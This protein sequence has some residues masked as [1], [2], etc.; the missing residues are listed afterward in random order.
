MKT[1]FL[2]C[3]LSL[4]ALAGWGQAVP[5]SYSA[6]VEVP[7]ASQSE[8]FGRAL[9]WLV[10]LPAV[11]SAQ[12]AASGTILAQVSSPIKYSVLPLLLVRN[13]SLQVKD[14][15]LRYELTGFALQ[16]LDKTLDT[17]RGVGK[18]TPL[19]KWPDRSGKFTA[20]VNAQISGQ[21]EALKAGLTTAANW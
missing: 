11:P 15:R 17:P 8:L 18:L 9:K 13:V 1:L 2:G 12:D 6:V 4:S 19:E 16:G 10:G 3:A 20:E 7:G 14:G 21:L 5:L